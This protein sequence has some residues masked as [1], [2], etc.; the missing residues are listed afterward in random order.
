MRPIALS[1]RRAVRRWSGRPQGADVNPPRP[2]FP[3]RYFDRRSNRLSRVA[4]EKCPRRQARQDKHAFHVDSSAGLERSGAWLGIHHSG[5]A[6]LIADRRQGHTPP[7][8]LSRR[9]NFFTFSFRECSF[10]QSR[11]HPAHDARALLS[12]ADQLRFAH[13]RAALPAR[14]KVIH[15]THACRLFHRSHADDPGACLFVEQLAFFD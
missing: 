11:W 7:H 10:R 14:E 6:W 1:P 3:R 5:V 4:A 15:D 9:T 8:L 13:Q 2:K 12:L